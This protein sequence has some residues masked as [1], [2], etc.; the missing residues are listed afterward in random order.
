MIAFSA[1]S[2]LAKG[3][4]PL[5]KYFEIMKTNAQRLSLKVKHLFLK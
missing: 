5:E 2:D 1:A 3:I 4:T